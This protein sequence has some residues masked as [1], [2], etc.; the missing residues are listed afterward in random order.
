MGPMK[1]FTGE[2]QSGDQTLS[3]GN[4]RIAN[5]ENVPMFYFIENRQPSGQKNVV[6]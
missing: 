6:L 3:G 4:Q 5:S 1:Y 2:G